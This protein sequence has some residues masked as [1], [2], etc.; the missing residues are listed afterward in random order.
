MRV[1]T[2][3]YCLFGVVALVCIVGGYYSYREDLEK[4]HRLTEEAAAT[5]EKV[6]VRRMV[7]PVMGDERTVDIGVTYSYVVE[8]RSF[9]RS[10]RMSKRSASEF[11]PWDKAKICYDPADDSTVENGRL[12]PRTHSCGRD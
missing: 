3:V 10:V 11:V 1:R 5:V 2:A 7:D 4:T 9:R 12:F 6:D 8:G